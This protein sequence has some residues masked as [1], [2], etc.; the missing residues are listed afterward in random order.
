[1]KFSV[2]AKEFAMAI[3][4]PVDVASKNTIKGF[5]YEGYLTLHAVMAEL[6]LCAFGGG[7]SI[8]STI[9]DTFSALVQYKCEEEG[10]ATIVA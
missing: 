7:A 4:S 5:K 6:K 8:T 9:S 10:T 2:N 1:M 3:S